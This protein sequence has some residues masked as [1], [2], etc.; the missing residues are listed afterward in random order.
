MLVYSTSYLF[1]VLPMLI[2]QSYAISQ[3]VYALNCLSWSLLSQ[4]IYLNY[5][6]WCIWVFNFLKTSFR[7]QMSSID[8]RML[9]VFNGKRFI[10]MCST[11]KVCLFVNLAFIGE[12]LIDSASMT[13]SFSM[14]WPVY[15]CVTISLKLYVLSIEFLIFDRYS[16]NIY[17]NCL[18]IVIAMV[19]AIF[20]MRVSNGWWF[21]EQN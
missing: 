7:K 13:F 4:N 2:P 16:Y 6:W 8:L 17:T 19:D 11:F 20:I 10:M 18:V 1:S 15:D 14:I 9:K 12:D 21:S 5:T 3:S